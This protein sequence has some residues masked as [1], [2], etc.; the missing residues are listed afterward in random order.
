MNDFSEDAI[1]RTSLFTRVAE[2][3]N[4]KVLLGRYGGEY[5]NDMVAISEKITRR[6]YG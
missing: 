4:M 5:N 6:Y 1:R 3:N 2:R